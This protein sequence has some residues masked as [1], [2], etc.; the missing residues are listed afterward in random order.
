MECDLADNTCSNQS[1]SSE[2]HH[3]HLKFNF[4][5]MVLKSKTSVMNQAR[6]RKTGKKR[7]KSNRNKKYEPV[8]LTKRKSTSYKA[9]RERTKSIVAPTYNSQQSI[10]FRFFLKCTTNSS[11]KGLMLSCDTGGAPHP[12]WKVRKPCFECNKKIKKT[13]LSS[14]EQPAASRLVLITTTYMVETRV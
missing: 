7:R 4:I 10:N 5:Y 2:G 9:K 13:C 3:W 12:R 6:E 8:K 1:G 14:H 11:H